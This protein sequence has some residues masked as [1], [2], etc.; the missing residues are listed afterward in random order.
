MG[1]KYY[2]ILIALF[3]GTHIINAQESK[4]DIDKQA[5]SFFKKGEFVEATPLFLRLLS[6]EP[7]NPN[8][9]YKYGTCLL[10]NADKNKE[11]FKYLNYSIQKDSEVEPEAY[12]Y[13]GKAYHLSYRFDKAI[14]N[15]EIYKQK[16]G[17]KALENL[18]VSRQIEMC[19]NGKSQFSDFTE[20]IVLEKTQIDLK[21]FFRIY[22]LKDIG[23]NLIVAEEFQSKQDK[24]NN[25]TPLIHFPINSDYIYYSSYGQDSNNKDI[26]FRY[27]K[28]DGDW[29]KESPVL[30]DVNTKYN[31]DYPYMHPNGKY[32]YFSSEGHKSM[33]G[34]DV[35]RS[36]YDPSTNTFGIPENMN[37]SVSSPDNDFL[38]I[39]DSLDKYAYFAS[40][41]ESETKNVHVYKVRLERMPMQTILLKGDYL[42]SINPT[43]KNISIKVNDLAGNL[44]G[45]FKSDNKGEYNIKLPKSGKYEFIVKLDR[46]EKE[47]REIIEVP[48]S[49][50]FRPLKQKI[51]QIDKE[52]QHIIVFNNLFNEK[53]ENYD[54]ILA[55]AIEAK[56]KMEI[57]K[58]LYNLDSLDRIKDEQ[59]K[60]DK[61]GL[62]EYTNV[63]IQDLIKTKFKDLYTRQT[64]TDS[65]LQKSKYIVQTG[66]QSIKRALKSA[67]SLVSLSKE[68]PNDPEVDKWNRISEQQL[69]KSKKLQTELLNAQII[70]SFLEK[71]YVEKEA[72]LSQSKSLNDGIKNINTSN[73]KELIDVLSKYPTFVSEELLVRTKTNAYFEYLGVINDQLRLRDNLIVRKDSLK[74][75]EQS[76]KVVLEKLRRDY[77]AASSRAREDISFE[78]SKAEIK[79][80][81]LVNEIKYTDEVIAEKSKVAD[82]KEVLAQI[83]RSPIKENMISQHD[84]AEE[85]ENLKKELAE[86][87]TKANAIPK[88]EELAENSTQ[89]NETVET[90][91]VPEEQQEEV[92]AIEEETLAE[93]QTEINPEE[94]AATNESNEEATEIE[95]T[96]ESNI[97]EE[98]ETL[99]IPTLFMLDPEY[100]NDIAQI[101]SGIEEGTI[102]K[103][104][105]L[106]R[107][108]KTVTKIQDAKVTVAEQIAKNP[109]DQSLQKTSLSLNKL[110]GNLFNEITL[111]TAE[112][113]AENGLIAGNQET[114]ETPEVNE[115]LANEI[116]S[117]ETENLAEQEEFV[118]KENTSNVSNEEENTIEEPAVIISTPTLAE[119]DTDYSS[120]IAQL[121]LDLETGTRNKVD[122]ISRKNQA[123]IKVKDVKV[124]ANEK[125]ESQPDNIALNT[126][127]E[128]LNSIENTLISEI[129]ALENE[130]TAENEM[131]VEALEN[132][133]NEETNESNIAES[134]S[135][136]S[137]NELPETEFTAENENA[138]GEQELTSSAQLFVEIDPD[139]T[140]DIAQIEQEINEGSLTKS[141]LIKRNYQAVLKVHDIK[142]KTIVLITENPEDKVLVDK[143]DDLA[144]L[145]NQI[146]S[147][148]ESIEYEIAEKNELMAQASSQETETNPAAFQEESNT[149]LAENSEE[150]NTENSETD[151][152]NNETTEN[153]ENEVADV[154]EMNAE[155]QNEESAETNPATFEEVTNNELAENSEENNTE[156]SETDLANNETTENLE[157]EVA[158]VNEMNAG[159]QNEE[160]IETN[161]AASQ[162]EVNNELAEN[163]VENNSENSETGLA[164]NETNEN[165]E[166]EVADVNELN[167]ETQ[168][169]ESA[170]TNP[171]AS[172][173]EVNNELAENSVE[174]NSENSETGLAENETNENLENEVAVVNELNTGTQNEESA[175]T[176]PAASQE[177]INNE[178]AENSAE[179][180]SENSETGLAE[181]E[182]NENLENEVAVVNELNTG[183][184]N[185]ESA[186]TNPAA[187]QE[188]V[189]NEL[190]E[191]SVEN[192]SE[193]SETGLAEN[194]TNENLENEV[195]AINKLNVETQNEETT[196]EENV[197]IANP[198]EML[199]EIDPDYL[200][201]IAE[202]E[203][204][205]K[206][207]TQTNKELIKRKYKVLISVGDVKTETIKEEEQNS[208]PILKQKVAT[209]TKIENQIVNE[210]DELER[211][212]LV[213]SSENKT[214]PSVDAIQLITSI[215]KAAIPNQ[216][217]NSLGNN[218]QE[219]LNDLFNEKDQ[220]EQEIR[221]NPELAEDKKVRKKLERI[222]NTIATELNIALQNSLV[223]TYPKLVKRS[224]KLMQDA[225]EEVTSLSTQQSIVKI[226]QLLQKSSEKKNAVEIYSLFQEA[227]NEQE[228]ALQ[229]IEDN[230][231]QKQI[232]SYIND[233]VKAQNLEN[234][235]TETVA[236]TD[237]EIMKEQNQINLK[238]VNLNEQI[239]ELNAM[240]P[241]AK[242]Q[243]VIS[244]EY[245]INQLNQI[246][247]G[248]ENKYY[249]NSKVLD[250]KETQQLAD[251][252]KGISKEAIK[253]T[254]T[255]QEEVEIAQSKE[256]ID[257]LKNN[258]RLTQAQFELRVKEEQL[259]NQQTE[260][261]ET[262]DEIKTSKLFNDEKKENINAQ[263]NTISK[264]KNEVQ[265]LRENVQ[266]KQADVASALPSDPGLRFKTENMIARD[267]APLKA[268]PIRTSSM[269]LMK[270]GLSIG[271]KKENVYSDENPIPIIEKQ[272]DQMGGLIFRVQIGAFRNPVPNV[273]FSEFS[274]I[275]G[276]QI[277]SGWIKYVVGLFGNKETASDARD[278]IRTMGYSDAFVV[279]YCDGER[280]PVYRAVELASSGACISLINPDED[281]IANTESNVETP[282][283][284]Q[285]LDEMAYNKSVG[286]AEADVVENKAGLFYTVQVGVYNTP[287]T[288]EQLN[289]V[290]PLITKRLPTGLIRYSSGIFNSYDEA[291]PKKQEV[292]AKGIS[293]AYIV[294]YYKGLRIS[295]SQANEILKS[296]GDVVLQS[297]APE[298]R[299]NIDETTTE[300]N[301]N[302][303]EF[304]DAF[305]SDNNTKNMLVSSKSYTE[306][307]IQELNRYNEYGELFYYDSKTK[308]IQSF[309]FDGKT[310]TSQFS[311]DFNTKAVYNYAY[312][313]VDVKTPYR[314]NAI[315]Y[316]E[317]NL[318][319]LEVSINNED[320][321]SDLMEA[322]L[323]TPVTKQM[324]TNENQLVVNFYAVDVENNRFIVD[325][326]QAVLTK[327]GATEVTKTAQSF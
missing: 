110:E 257:Q 6:L 152:A 59:R 179:N 300:V 193:N 189:N 101:E 175:E 260:L 241:N 169:E 9:N 103:S 325:R 10:Y 178:L 14:K 150:N 120:D 94:I 74:R 239:N 218:E 144:L 190:A 233:L 54:E 307:P 25:H 225:P 58:D 102:E 111:L 279:A 64:S 166:N 87:E 26:Y 195:A 11:A 305:I 220:L 139:F 61:I 21:S 158:N 197:S 286:S 36:V 115:E 296:Q 180:N 212:E 37:I 30:G 127:I 55:E 222:D 132:E 122:L 153:L 96:E 63:E 199:M 170:E 97:V 22:D 50:S 159:T 148:I 98:K 163:S 289:N 227:Y 89:N 204:G 157:N 123:I 116:A 324:K 321:N 270:T 18:Q 236:L 188:E 272:D 228:R 84:L 192:N 68:N 57:N 310:I 119:I 155:T 196:I 258:N 100:A 131:L 48:K 125:R 171:A 211:V 172:Q 85:F 162:E 268:M 24:K 261:K 309:L 13:L 274:P 78:L 311:S 43:L 326:L 138:S 168:N 266:S 113:D 285:K 142:E 7:R 160:S 79:L 60:F 20:T 298:K 244:I 149:E 105:L 277:G 41:R 215:S 253:N 187:S 224:D 126:V 118:N 265:R 312:P 200:N 301:T 106:N 161:P 75:E 217:Q 316:S 34:Y 80:E 32:L 124:E 246:K 243:D 252:N 76:T 104:D 130:I 267:V 294:A 5:Q 245:N 117:T 2:T 276:D 248:L 82:Q 306:Y 143:L 39:V 174:N 282:R 66:N 214:N 77:E 29:S 46:D 108:T 81:G 154:N 107:K 165:L 213:V 128:E 15:Y 242:K 151:L 141:E 184:Q 275:T 135:E 259:K 230:K 201:D 273:T 255:Y 203:Q 23:G 86:I 40:Q 304:Q 223:T 167:T 226:E 234:I 313:I 232:N 271:E 293:D 281:L 315:E 210:I 38:Y 45:N 229:V 70:L 320:L 28:A 209:I 137:E 88:N 186:E 93:Q 95:N 99:I 65:L 181:N 31:E 44:I 308:R 51:A 191:N 256:Y 231:T 182:T 280:I 49:K 16:A 327:L 62:A 299:V 291:L 219:R 134:E 269:A 3:F 71:D 314:K 206:E 47:Y 319:H 67:D 91:V 284:A 90:E 4:E 207:G 145:E 208:T 129:A 283:S 177:E 251:A 237:S 73:T 221:A 121:E 287:A 140:N 69:E 249:S 235:E 176:N 250:E 56:A 72:L 202:I 183:T 303:G 323:N 262:Y 146:Y 114:E 1:L 33:G 263:L 53:V 185:E 238:L 164:E 205:I 19:R 42:S 147:D 288:A 198:A 92:E 112:I 302:S 12:Y 156:N 27:R 254:L 278:K 109:N 292:V 17:V 247:M 52:G 295:A 216:I 240:I 173:E 8:Y 290:S 133:A 297:N 264:T 136:V 318:I 322:I 194:E 35:F 83:S 317:S